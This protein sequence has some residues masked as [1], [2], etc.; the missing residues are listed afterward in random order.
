MGNSW[1]S[2]I[3]VKSVP[4]PNSDEQVKF[5]VNIQRLL[6]EGQFVATYKYALLLAL[7]DIAVEKG[8]QKYATAKDAFID[9]FKA[10]E[11]HLTID[12]REYYLTKAV[13]IAKASGEETVSPE[14]VVTATAT[15]E[16]E[17]EAVKEKV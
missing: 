5:L 6:A 14:T 17:D 1:Q 9:N 7:A 3:L 8:E 15:V 10:L 4:T 13:E 2:K 12:Q 11:P 16:P